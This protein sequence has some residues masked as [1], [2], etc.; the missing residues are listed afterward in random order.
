[1]EEEEHFQIKGNKNSDFYLLQ[2]ARE[3]FLDTINQ[4]DNAGD[5]GEYV[6]VKIIADGDAS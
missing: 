2:A 1:M 4:L 5:L 3:A 6:Q